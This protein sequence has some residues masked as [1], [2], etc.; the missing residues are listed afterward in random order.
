M[1]V[2]AEGENRVSREQT[3]YQKQTDKGKPHM[4]PRSSRSFS[5]AGYIPIV[6]LLICCCARY[7]I[8]T[9]QGILQITFIKLNTSL[10]P[11]S[12]GKCLPALS[13]LA[14]V[15]IAKSLS[16]VSF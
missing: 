6:T 10:P 11:I 9:V 2:Q 14:Q 12:G 8:I 16:C 7:I 3:M 1:Q 4:L 15:S 13:S 5:K